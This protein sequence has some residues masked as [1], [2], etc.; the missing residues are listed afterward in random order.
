MMARDRDRDVEARL[1]LTAE[2]KS[3]MEARGDSE[4]CAAL[5]TE[6]VEILLRPSVVASIEL[7]TENFLHVID[8]GG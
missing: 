6:K 8:R 5:G 2:N 1:G 3:A 4:F 7:L